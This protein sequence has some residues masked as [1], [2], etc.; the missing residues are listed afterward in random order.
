MRACWVF[1][2]ALLALGMAFGAAQAQDYPTQTI[3]LI[4]PFTPGGPVDALGR[5]IIQHLQSR[6]GQTIVVENRPGGGTTIGAKQV[7]AAPPDGY[8][9]LLV[10]PNVAYYPVLFPK[11][12]FDPAKGLLPVATLVTWS[13]VFAVA[14][15]VPAKTIAELVAHAKANPGKLAFG[16]GLGTMPHIL[17]ESL[18]RETGIDIVRVPYRG[19]SQARADLLGGRV[20][21]NIAPPPQLLPLIR[22]GKIRAL[23]YTAAQR[24]PDMPEVPTM[25]ESGFPQIGFHPDVW[26]GIFAPAGTPPAIV[27]KLNREVNA[28]LKS[29]EM[30][31]V[32]KRYAYEAM[33]TTPAEFATF[34]ASQL[35]KWPPVLIAAGLKPQ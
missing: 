26:M 20:H 31:P 15:S 2:T 32:L 9:L 29:A 12:D 25:I 4:V 28:V 27:D 24:S 14:P 22:D 17:G 35:R 6:L 33:V 16:Y 23:A 30:A 11:L 34:Y 13:H 5:V 19:G 3:K 7:A 1:T 10:G 8:T 21:L 18:I